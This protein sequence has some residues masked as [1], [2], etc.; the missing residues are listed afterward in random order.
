MKL[1]AP[2]AGSSLYGSAFDVK[3]GKW[4]DWLS[5]VPKQEISFDM[6]FTQITVQT[7]DSIRTTYL[8][9]KLI[10]GHYQVSTKSQ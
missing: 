5:T 2:P 6:E 10:K 8:L 9:D 1:P 7:I 4:V 3:T